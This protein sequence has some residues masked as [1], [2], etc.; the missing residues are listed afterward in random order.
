MHRTDQ[1]L[2]ERSRRV[3][4]LVQERTRLEARLNDLELHLLT[5]RRA[6]DTTAPTSWVELRTQAS[7]FEIRN[8]VG[9]LYLTGAGIEIGALHSPLKLASDVSI[10][11]VDRMSVA[12]LRQHYP[13]LAAYDLIEPDIVD[14]A[15]HLRSLSDESQDFVI[16]NHYLEHCQDPI[17]AMMTVCRVVRPG[18]LI[19]L[20]V[21]DKRF[22]FDHRRPITPFEH[23]V[24]D[25]E[26]GPA[27]SRQQHFEEWAQLGEDE[28]TRGKSAAALMEMDYSIH[29]HVW[30]QAELIEFFGKLRVEYGLPLSIEFMILNVIEIIFVLRKDAE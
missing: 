4:D 8:T 5:T 18:G 24:R 22:T 9:G 7:L 26:S 19:Y 21:P 12:D 28:S 11:Y 2:L 14:D 27:W 10:R 16:A 3:Y 20:A 30:T 1:L 6:E 29:F 15:E 17:G 25:H 23:L 13:E